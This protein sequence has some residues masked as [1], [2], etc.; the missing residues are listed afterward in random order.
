M[1]ERH[2]VSR[3]PGN[4]LQQL[5]ARIIDSNFSNFEGHSEWLKEQGFNIS[6]SGIHNYATEVM[7]KTNKDG[8]IDENRYRDAELRM[9]C[10]QSAIAIDPKSAVVDVAA[11]LYL[12]VTTGRR[13]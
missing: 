12:W 9:K 6:K 10:L 1:T 3:L 4:V 8:S 13:P 5:L 7:R 11:G 2:A